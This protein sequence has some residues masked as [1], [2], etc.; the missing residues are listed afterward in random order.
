MR[1][2]A[3]SA[4]SP[5]THTYAHT[6]THTPLLNILGNKCAKHNSSAQKIRIIRDEKLTAVKVMMN[7]R[8][9]PSVARPSE[10][11]LEA[12]RLSLIKQQP[13]HLPTVQ[14]LFTNPIL[15]H[16]HTQRH[17]HTLTHTHTH[18]H[19]RPHTHPHTHSNTHTPTHPPTPRPPTHSPPTRPRPLLLGS[20]A[21]TDPRN[22]LSASVSTATS[23][24]PG[25]SVAHCRCDSTAT[26]A[27]ASTREGTHSTGRGLRVCWNRR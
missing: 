21:S 17:T 10:W 6:H 18:T 12:Q 23:L 14:S 3:A 5:H 19:T 9:F 8:F 15:L 7:L 26:I 1:A 24:A 20:P 25:Y 4:H 27:T 2:G 22:S 13:S 16:T 11:R